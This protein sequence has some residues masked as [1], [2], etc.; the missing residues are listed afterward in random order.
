MPFCVRENTL[1]Q[2]TPIHREDLSGLS[3]NHRITEARIW[4]R[5]TR[6]EGDPNSRESALTR[7]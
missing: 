7:A 2:E 6:C 1:L 3:T 4:L 5:D